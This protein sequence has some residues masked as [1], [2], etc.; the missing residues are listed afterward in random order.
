GMTTVTNSVTI[1]ARNAIDARAEPTRI[2]MTWPG[3]LSRADL[4]VAFIDVQSARKDQRAITECQDDADVAETR[5]KACHDP[6]KVGDRGKQT[7]DVCDTEK[8]SSSPK[9]E[10]SR[11]H[12]CGAAMEVV[13][14]GQGPTC[15]RHPAY[16][17]DQSD[18]AHD[19]NVT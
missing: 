6:P 9:V 14:R 5:T 15:Q 4:G 3:E 12:N 16:E 1:P 7:P 13:R 8:S 10:A 19:H 17:G 2:A 11:R 18:Q